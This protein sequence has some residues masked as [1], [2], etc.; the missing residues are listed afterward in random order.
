MLHLRLGFIL[1]MGVIVRN[2][3]GE[4][5]IVAWIVGRKVIR[6]FDQGGS[7][8]RRTSPSVFCYFLNTAEK[9]GKNPK[10]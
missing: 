1:A 9:T 5:P 2:V 4:R 10:K 8:G 7:N 3:F 6:I